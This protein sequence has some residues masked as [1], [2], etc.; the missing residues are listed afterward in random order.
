MGN[1]CRKLRLYIRINNSNN[2]NAIICLRCLATLNKNHITNCN[3]ADIKWMQASFPIKDCSQ[4]LGRVAS[5]ALPDLL[6]SAADTQSLH[7]TILSSV[8]Y[9]THSV[10]DSNVVTF[11]GSRSQQPVSQ[12][13][14]K[15]SEWD[16]SRNLIDKY[17]QR[18]SP[19]SDCLSNS[20]LQ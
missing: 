12:L 19:I 4:S 17:H 11:S 7:I 2:A 13:D 6:A 3:L 8:Q 18:M 14:R 20:Q 1:Y 9:S 5:L 15:Q 16:R 10:L